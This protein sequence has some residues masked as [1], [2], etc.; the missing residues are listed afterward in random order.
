MHDYRCYYVDANNHVTGVEQVTAEDDE[1]AIEAA[2]GFLNA[3]RWSAVGIEVWER[4]R[5]IWRSREAEQMTAPPQP[6]AIP[7]QATMS[8]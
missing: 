4:D 1:A 5:R 7:R 2:K 8:D 6:K 3:P